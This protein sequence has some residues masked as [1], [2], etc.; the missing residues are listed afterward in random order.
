[1]SNTDIDDWTTLSAYHDGELPAQAAADIAARLQHEPQLRAMLIEIETLSAGLKRLRP[2]LSGPGDTV[3]PLRQARNPVLYRRPLAI[4]ASVAVAAVMAG[5]LVMASI[6]P[7]RDVAAWHAEFLTQ[8]Y[9]VT[10]AGDTVEVS[11][12][13]FAQMP[14]LSAAGLAL[15]DMRD[16]RGGVEAYHFAGQNA[17]RLT[18]LV[19]PDLDLG[20]G[21]ED[22]M[23]RQWRAGKLGYVAVAARMDGARFA[24]IVRYLENL[25]RQASTG[26]DVLA[27]RAAND[28]AARC[29]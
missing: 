15:V 3:V 7:G 14:D 22:L 21:T 12:T 1:M 19:G 4:A 29:T 16:G 23:S 13:A 11:A 20:A 5:Y 26:G 17:C 2:A 8:G 6:G 10:A 25:T 18:V 27:M 9:D 24:T 28:A